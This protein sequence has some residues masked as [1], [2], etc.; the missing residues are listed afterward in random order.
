MVTS[1]IIGPVHLTWILDQS[2]KKRFLHL[3][4]LMLISSLPTSL[5]L[6]F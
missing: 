6:S 5:S 1:G 4:L 2:L 3:F